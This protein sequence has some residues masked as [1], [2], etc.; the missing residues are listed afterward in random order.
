MK[1]VFLLLFKSLMFS[2]EL[3]IATHC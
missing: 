3:S 1:K 2:Q